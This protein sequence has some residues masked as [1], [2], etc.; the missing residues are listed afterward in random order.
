MKT[1]IEWHPWP[2]EK[3]P[4]DDVEYIVT[5]KDDDGRLFMAHR[6]WWDFSHVIAWAY[7]IDPYRR[8]E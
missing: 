1:L 5:I 7:P 8:K 3:P 4:E 2:E 6:V